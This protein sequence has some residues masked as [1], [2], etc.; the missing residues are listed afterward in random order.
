[1][2]ASTYNLNALR[3]MFVAT[4]EMWQLP[5]FWLTSWCDLIVDSWEE[6]RDLDRGD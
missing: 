1:M 2:T 6:A 5:R 4:E 3:T